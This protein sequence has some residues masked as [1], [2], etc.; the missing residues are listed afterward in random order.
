MMSDTGLLIL[1]REACK[2]LIEHA[3]EDFMREL[4]NFQPVPKPVNMRQIFKCLIESIATKTMKETNCLNALT[5]PS[6]D[7]REAPDNT[8]S[9]NASH[10]L[11][12][13]SISPEL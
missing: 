11:T 1:Y 13:A 5:E 12:Y 3:G 4:E 8:P 2:F 6:R 9:L 10:C 7:N